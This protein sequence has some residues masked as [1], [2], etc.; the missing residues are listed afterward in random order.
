MERENTLREKTESSMPLE[1]N[2]IRLPAPSMAASYLLGYIYVCSFIFGFVRLPFWGEFLGIPVTLWFRLLFAVLF[3]A[4]GEYV[5]RCKVKVL[6]NKRGE[7]GPKTP[8]EHW[9]WMA[10]TFLLLLAEVLGRCR[11]I[12]FE[13]RLLYTVAVHGSA[14]YWALCRFGQLTENQTGP[15]F[16][17]DMLDA[18]V[19]TPFGGYMLRLR[20]HG[21]TL[22]RAAE[23]LRHR[24][25]Q[26]I[27]WK[28]AGTTVGVVVLSL[29]AFFFVGSLLSDADTVGFAEFWQGLIDILQFR[30]PK[31]PD[32]F[33]DVAVRF[34]FSL[35][36]GAYL[37][38]LLGSC[39]RRH[40]SV[41]EAEKARAG[42]ERM[43]MVPPVAAVTVFLLFCG[44]YIV[45]FAY[46]AG[47]L[48]GAF[49]GV[50]P[51]TA[52]AAQYAREGFFQ[53]CQVMTI[54]FGLLLAAA[55]LCTTP[56]R[57]HKGLKALSLLLMLQ[58]VLLAVTAASKL[59]L[60]IDR[61]GFTPLR[62]LSA[63]AILVLAAGS[64]LA[65][66]SIVRPFR[67]VQKW[68]WFSMASF[69]LLCLY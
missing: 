66:A 8:T 65:A 35:P 10:C 24:M 41:L 1:R 68:I 51:G 22:F 14:A 50:V 33:G 17:W 9:F 60:Y 49:F 45:F 53:L 34:V 12:D 21:Q 5:A 56:L 20:A 36:V 32:W 58:S 11:A 40:S 28:H 52:T 62:L 27:S 46:Q 42:A 44:L 38:G 7:S 16:V 19:T 4:W 23:T 67:A 47:H 15:F 64:V 3:F 69:V 63:W 30:W 25:K 54:N 59:W 13:G 39:A 18:L 26:K 55:K 61:F 31:L 43:R 29:P 2:D 37:Y 57:S 48:F 6:V